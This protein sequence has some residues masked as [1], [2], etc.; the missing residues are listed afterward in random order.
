M[1]LI[2]LFN[3]FL[4]NTN[5]LNKNMPEFFLSSYFTIHH[6]HY[7]NIPF[8]S[9]FPVS[10]KQSQFWEGWLYKRSRGSGCDPIFEVTL[11]RN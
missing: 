9:K 8:S 10:H 5:N 11:Y 2:L 1:K 7:I 3:M 4:Q 6:P